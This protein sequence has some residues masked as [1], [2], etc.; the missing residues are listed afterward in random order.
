MREETHSNIM[1]LN[2][3]ISRE[4]LELIFRPATSVSVGGKSGEFVREIAKISIEGLGGDTP[5]LPAESIKGTLRSMAVTIANT[6]FKN[7]YIGHHVPNYNLKE[8]TDKYRDEAEKT[9]KKLGFTDEQ[10]GEL[11][12]SE[13]VDLY[14]ALNCPVCRLFGWRGLAG[15]L[16]VSDGIPN[17]RP[18]LRY[19]TST[20]IDR[21]LGLA[22][23]KR[24]FTIESIEKDP[25]LRF[26]IK[27]IIDNMNG[28]EARLICMLL[29]MISEIGLRIGG[30]KSRGYGL[31][32]MDKASK[33]KRIKF[34]PQ[35]KNEEEI[36][37]NVKALLLKEGYFEQLTIEEYINV[38]REMAACL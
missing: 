26:N 38:L 30:S 12:E 31:L 27:I 18:R 2:K 25:E 29:Q 21:K 1:H 24:L 35:P 23:E 14:L 3:L 34:I 17:K 20:A 19:F 28:E 15:K 5:F 16:T 36:L 22:S 7:D 4:I 8:I 37:T 10:I 32:E 13:R 11:D 33:V 9:L 6:I